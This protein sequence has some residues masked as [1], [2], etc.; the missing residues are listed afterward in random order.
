MKYPVWACLLALSL[1]ASIPVRAENQV[2]SVTFDSIA[3]LENKRGESLDPKL[4]SFGKSRGGDEKSAHVSTN[5]FNKTKA[6]ACRWAL[7]GG[8]LK[9]QK[10]AL[11][12][13]ERVVDVR[14]YA[15]NMESASRDR[16]LCLAGGIIVRSVI[17][18]SY[19]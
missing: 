3:Q 2:V 7:L 14:T 11:Q 16:C 13:G 1:C 17:K 4:F 19:H 12:K 5:G 18:A 8:F 10:K 6:E 15:G 9:F